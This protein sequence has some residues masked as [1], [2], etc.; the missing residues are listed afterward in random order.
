VT[1]CSTG[2]GREIARIVHQAG[3][4]IVATA[5]D[6]NS[7]SYLPDD[8]KVLKISLDVTSKAAIKEAI[9]TT[10]KKFGRLDVAV[11]NAGYG[12]AG[13]TEVVPD[14]AAR[15]EMETL[16]W[17]PVHVTQEVLPIF[18]EVNPQGGTIVNVSS[19][20]G[21]LTFPGNAFYHAGYDRSPNRALAYI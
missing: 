17:G 9:A 21:W 1:G 3:Q 11:N 14:E 16:F 19:I 15:L 6:V 13:D 8:P 7:L 18:R 10:V 20:G 2:L 5:R 12:L 4:C